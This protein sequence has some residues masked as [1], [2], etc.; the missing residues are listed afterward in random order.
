VDAEVADDFGRQGVRRQLLLLLLSCEKNYIFI[1]LAHM[2]QKATSI[3]TA[4]AVAT[5]WQVNVHHRRSPLA[6]TT[7]R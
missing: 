1:C 5:E 7:N 3:A 2:K 6:I 4:T